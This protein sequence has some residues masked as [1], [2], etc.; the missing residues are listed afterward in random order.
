[1]LWVPIEGPYMHSYFTVHL[2]GL[3]GH[4]MCRINSILPNFKYIKATEV[5]HMTYLKKNTVSTLQ[6]QSYINKYLVIKKLGFT[7]TKIPFFFEKIFFF[8][9]SK[10]VNDGDDEN[11]WL[12]LFFYITHTGS[13]RAWLY[14]C[15]G[16]WGW[17]S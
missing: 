12:L 9:S 11:H 15:V 1:M 3:F 14:L 2:T 5:T 6:R 16:I 17:W 10:W 13:W 8:I 4:N 7:T